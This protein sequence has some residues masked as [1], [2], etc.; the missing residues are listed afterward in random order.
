[1]Y[2]NLHVRLRAAVIA[3]DMDGEEMKDT[4]KPGSRSIPW[5]RIQF[6]KR[7]VLAATVE[8]KVTNAQDMC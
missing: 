7:S 2:V 5:A 8:K 4:Q 6:K 3:R 1:M